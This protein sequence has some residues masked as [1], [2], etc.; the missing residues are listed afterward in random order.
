MIGI[1]VTAAVAG[2]CLLLPGYYAY[3]A[4]TVATTTLTGIGLNVLL[5]LAG[6]I[7]LGQVGFVAL[8]AYGLGILTATFHV[9]FVLALPASVLLVVA[10]A[11]LVAIPALRVSGPY[12]AMMTIAFGF[13]VVSAATEWQALTGGASGLPG[14]PPPVVAG[15]VFTIGHTAAMSVVV[16]ALALAGFAWLKRSPLGLA[17][18]AGADAPIA[19]RGIG[20]DLLAVRALAFVIAAGAAG[21]AGGLQAALAGLIAPSSFPFSASILFLLVVIVGGIGAT[22]APLVGAVLV[23]LLPQLFAGF[24]EYQLLV[25]GA[26]LFVVLRIAPRGLVG[27]FVRA[28]V[29]RST[30]EPISASAPLRIAAKQPVDLEVRDLSVAFGGVQAIADLGFTATS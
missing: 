30:G 26:G 9:P 24:A 7:S 12:L 4:A 3:L 14:I 6:E 15:H 23:V 13:I 17:M 25:F 27:M 10:V 21:L 18:R 22:L 19:A 5:G 11:A 8:G 16:V 20:I 1:L 29:S 28:R 2:A